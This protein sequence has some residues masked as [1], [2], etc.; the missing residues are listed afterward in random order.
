MIGVDK[1]SL[2]IWKLIISY[3][4]LK[5]LEQLIIGYNIFLILSLISMVGIPC[6]LPSKMM[7]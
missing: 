3:I 6:V 7:V 1:T 2:K 5:N 4:C